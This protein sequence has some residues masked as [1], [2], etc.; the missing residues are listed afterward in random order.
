VAR[1]VCGVQRHDGV[2]R[3]ELEVVE[4]RLDLGD[5][6]RGHNHGRE[7]GH[8]LVHQTLRAARVFDPA[9]HLQQT[10][11]VVFLFAARRV[12]QPGHDMGQ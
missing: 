2:P 6:V 7:K 10:G 5:L 4:E 1:C 11:N 3:L 12:R 9:E 8:Q